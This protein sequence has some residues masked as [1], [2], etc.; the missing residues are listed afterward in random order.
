MAKQLNGINIPITLEK[1]NITELLA[2]LRAEGGKLGDFGLSE[3]MEKDLAAILKKMDDTISEMNKKSGKLNLDDI[4]AKTSKTADELSDAFAKIF[5]N[6]DNLTNMS[7]KFEEMQSSIDKLNESLKGLGASNNIFDN[8]KQKMQGMREEITT[9][10][11]ALE[12]MMNN[13]AK[14]M[15]NTDAGRGA[16]NDII[17]KARQISGL[18]NQTQQLGVMFNNLAGGDIL[19]ID[20]KELK[21]IGKGF[22]TLVDQAPLLQNALHPKTAETSTTASVDKGQQQENAKLQRA[23]ELT[24]E[25]RK[26]VK[27]QKELEAIFYLNK[28]LNE[29]FYS[30]MKAFDVDE[31]SWEELSGYINSFKADYSQLGKIDIGTDEWRTLCTRMEEARSNA[32]ALHE[33]MI[34]V[35]MAETEEGHKKDADIW[36][37]NV[38]ENIVNKTMKQRFEKSSVNLTD[39]R[40][41]TLDTEMEFL[42][43]TGEGISPYLNKDYVPKT[44]E[45]TQATKELTE[46]VKEQAQATEEKPKF[47]SGASSASDD[48]NKLAKEMEAEQDPITNTKLPKDILEF[49]EKYQQSLQDTNI[50]LEKKKELLKQLVEFAN[51]AK[52]A[53][54]KMGA[55]SGDDNNA[56]EEMQQY[57][58]ELKKFDKMQ[59]TYGGKTPETKTFEANAAFDS[60]SDPEVLRYFKQVVDMRRS[61]VDIQFIESKQEEALEVSVKE[62]NVA[63]KEKLAILQQFSQA[64]KK[65]TDADQSYEDAET[66]KQEE[67]AD[68]D[69]GVAK[70]ELDDLKKLYH[71][72]IVTA[73]NEKIVLNVD[74]DEIED[75]LNEILK[76]KKDIQDVQIISPDQGK[77]IEAYKYLEKYLTRIEK[78]TVNY[79]SAGLPGQF[80]VSGYEFKDI[81][82][83]QELSQRLQNQEQSIAEFDPEHQLG[84]PAI[85]ERVE[86]CYKNIG[87]RLQAIMQEEK[88]IGDEPIVDEDKVTKLETKLEEVSNTLTE[89]KTKLDSIGTSASIDDTIDSYDKLKQKV[90]ELA[91]AES[92]IEKNK[93]ELQDTNY[94]TFALDRDPFKYTDMDKDSINDVNKLEKAIVSY[95][96]TYKKIESAI[97]NNNGMFGGDKHDMYSLDQMNTAIGKLLTQYVEL[98]GTASNV[99]DKMTKPFKQMGVDIQTNVVAVNKNNEAYRDE[100]DRLVKVNKLAVER[101]QTIR[102]TVRELLRGQNIKE[103]GGWGISVDMDSYDRVGGDIP[104]YDGYT[105]NF[106]KSEFVKVDQLTNQ[107][108]NELGIEIPS[109]SQKMSEALKEDVAKVT[110]TIDKLEHKVVELENKMAHSPATGTAPVDTLPVETKPETAQAA[111]PDTD[112]TKTNPKTEAETQDLETLRQKVLDVEKAFGAKTQAIIAEEKQMNSS[113]SA[114]VGDLNSILE[115]VNAIKSGLESI[116]GVKLTKEAVNNP[117]TE[118]ATKASKEKAKATD[119]ETKSNQK[120]SKSQQ[121]ANANIEDAL[122]ILKEYHD[123]VEILKNGSLRT[124]DTVRGVNNLSGLEADVTKVSEYAYN[125]DT[126]LVNKMNEKMAANY[127]VAADEKVKQEK[128]AQ[129]ERVALAKKAEDE[130]IALETARAKQYEDDKE[131][132]YW[133]TREAYLTE[134]KQQEEEFYRLQKA[135]LE[136]LAQEEEERNNYIKDRTNLYT[137]LF[138]QQEKSG[139]ANDIYKEFNSDTE[140]LESVKVTES[141]NVIITTLKQIDDKI[142][143]STYKVK[144]FYELFDQDGKFTLSSATPTYKY[145]R[146][147]TSPT[148]LNEDRQAITILEKEVAQQKEKIANIAE[149]ENDQALILLNVNEK[150]LENLKAQAAVKE[151]QQYGQFGNINK[152]LDSDNMKSAQGID[153]SSFIDSSGLTKL[154]SGMDALKAKMAEAEKSGEKLSTSNING[155]LEEA[156]ALEKIRQ[157]LM[158]NDNLTKEYRN[159][160]NASAK[161]QETLLKRLKEFR[162]TQMFNTTGNTLIDSK[163]FVQ[164][165]VAVE[166]LFNKIDQ[167]TQF[168]KG[169]LKEYNEEFVQLKTNIKEATKASNKKTNSQGSSIGDI[170]NLDQV[171]EEIKAIVK[172]LN[173]GNIEWGK[174]SKNKLNFVAT[175]DKKVSEYAATLDHATKNVRLLKTSEQDYQGSTGKFVSSIGRKMGEISRYVISMGSVYEIINF[176][177][178]GV[179]L[180]KDFD[181]A[182]TE[183]AKVSDDTTETLK[184]FGKE[185]FNIAKGVSSTGKE[186]V[187]STADW[188]RLGKSMQ[189]AG[190]MAENTAIL[191]NVSEFDS[192][193]TAT[194]A[195]VAMTSAF[196][197]SADKSLDLISAL[198]EIGNN[199]AISTSQLA[200]GLQSS[201]S[202]LVASGNSL[203]EA[204]ALMTA[205]NTTVQ[206]ADKVSAGLRTIALRLRGTSVSELSE[207]GEETDGVIETVSKLES[208][209]K[210]LTAIN[211]NMGVS[212]LDVNGNYKNTYDI[213][214]SIGDIW[215]EI[216]EADIADGINRQAG[217]L[218]LMAGK[219]RSNILAAVLSNSDILESAY[220]SSKNS[221]GSAL[222]ELGTYQKSITAH[223]QE[224]INQWQELWEK[225]LDSDTLTKIVDLGT[226]I[227]GVVDNVGLLKTALV[228][229][230]ALMAGFG[231]KGVFT[232]VEDSA[233]KAG[234]KIQFLGKTMTQW[235]STFSKGSKQSVVDFD[236]SSFENF[237]KE[238][239]G[240]TAKD[241]AIANNL[242]GVSDSTKNLAQNLNQA[243]VASGGFNAR[244]AVTDAYNKKVAIS[245]K[246]A[247]AGL[248]L[249]R[250]AM[251]T[252][253]G[254]AIAIL[255]DKIITGFSNLKSESEKLAEAAENAQKVIDQETENFDKQREAVDKLT[256]SYALLAQGVDKLT[257]KNIDLKP[258]DYEDYI[259]QS[260]QIAA[261]FPELVKGYD[262]EGNAIL[263]LSGSIDEITK[264]LDELIQKQREALNQTYA[265]EMPKLF[266]NVGSNVKEYSEDISDFIKDKNSFDELYEELVSDVTNY[267]TPSSAGNGKGRM[268]FG[269]QVADD[270]NALGLSLSKYS[271]QPSKET[272]W[273]PYLLP[274][275]E[276]L[277]EA[278]QTFE[279]SYDEQIAA[280]NVKIESAYDKL[281]PNFKGWLST[282]DD[283][284]G[285]SGSMQAVVQEIVGDIDWNKVA[286]KPIEEWTEASAYIK[287]NILTMFTNIAFSPELQEAYLSLFTLKDTGAAVSTFL[288]EYNKVID[289]IKDALGLT[290]EQINQ[291]KIILGVDDSID[292]YANAMQ[293]FAPGSSDSVNSATDASAIGDKN[294]IADWISTLTQEDIT[295]LMQIDFDTNASYKTYKQRLEELKQKTKEDK[296]D[297]AGE[298]FTKTISEASDKITGLGSALAT[299]KSGDMKNSDIEELLRK[300]PELAG[301]TDNLKEAM[302]NL[303]IA[304][305]DDAISYLKGEIDS[306]PPGSEKIKALLQYVDIIDG[307]SVEA[308]N[309]TTD[310]NALEEALGKLSTNAGLLQS[311]QDDMKD[312]KGGRIALNTLQSILNTYKDMEEPVNQYLSG[313]ITAKELFAKL[314]GAYK[315]D[316]Q[317][318]ENLVRAK[319]YFDKDMY[320]QVISSN[321]NRIKELAEAYDLDWE[322]WKT[323]EDAKLT[324]EKEL[325]LDLM[326]W[327]GKYYELTKQEDGTFSKQSK[328]VEDSDMP[329]SDA[330]RGQQQAS[331]IVDRYND[332]ITELNNSISSAAPTFDTSWESIVEDTTDGAEEAKTAIDWL[333]Q[334]LENLNK[335]V[336]KTKDLFEDAIDGNSVSGY[337]SNAKEVDKLTNKY[338]KLVASR[339]KLGSNYIGNVD[340]NNRPVLL[341]DDGGYSTSRTASETLWQGDDKGQNV[342]VHYTPI[343]P[344][345]TVL[346]DKELQDY[347]NNQLNDATDILNADKISNGGL[348][349]VY[350][351][352]TNLD[353]DKANTWDK[354]LHNAQDKMYGDEAAVLRGLEKAKNKSK[355]ILKDNSEEIYAS[356]ETYKTA[357]DQQIDGYTQAQET[358]VGRYASDLSKLGSKASEIQKKIE[359][360]SKNISEYDSETAEIINSAIANYNKIK[361][362]SDDIKAATSD[363]TE[364]D[365]TAAKEI[366]SGISDY[367]TKMYDNGLMSATDYYSALINANEKYYKGVAGL[368]DE[369]LDNELDLQSKLFDAKQAEFEKTIDDTVQGFK[370]EITAIDKELKGLNKHKDEM[371]QAIQAVTD[372]WDKESER[373]GDAQ[374]AEEKYYDSKIESIQEV[375]D[376]LQEQNDTQKRQIELEKA[377]AELERLKGQKTV[378]SLELDSNGNIHKVYE[379]DTAALREAQETLEDV[380]FNNHI[381]ELE[382]SIKVQQD[383]KDI[384]VKSY[385]ESIQRLSDLKENFLDATEA[386]AKMANAESAIKFFGNDWK[387]DAIAGK[388]EGLQGFITGYTEVQKVI[389][390]NEKEKEAIQEK[391]TLVEEFKE[392]YTEEM[393]EIVESIASLGLALE[394]TLDSEQ[395]AYNQKLDALISFKQAYDKIM[396]SLDAPAVSSPA[397]PSFLKGASMGIG[398]AGKSHSGMELGYIDKSMGGAEKD[399][400]STM[401][402]R[403]LKPNEIPRILEIGEGVVTEAQ[404]LNA[405]NNMKLAYNSGLTAG[406]MQSLLTTQNNSSSFD[407]N[408]ER[409]MLPEVNNANTFVTALKNIGSVYTQELYKN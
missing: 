221:E 4:L 109:A 31:S 244:Q 160:Q 374:E 234:K 106:D 406:Q 95:Y 301:Q 263:S 284:A 97:K 370:D 59:V 148:S 153:A 204:L 53:D 294:D 169:E 316:E 192:I 249:V 264:S 137:D 118:Q 210:S 99:T 91:D 172:S 41:R 225:T 5:A 197:V 288:D 391:Q 232:T 87:L 386:F 336:S 7:D 79:K 240:G 243:T 332:F 373:L 186:I 390:D 355:L 139:Y 306:L 300:F 142:Q 299:L 407:I 364:V 216:G 30:S 15:A 55:S 84:D 276:E 310:V 266:N 127:K 26:Q 185:S 273:F 11:K 108:A 58:G 85:L 18:V 180:V 168:S 344:D 81:N 176:F 290:E 126:G 233:A 220:N 388:L 166:S 80:G 302:T 257:G 365:K 98:G 110:T 105:E 43:L 201:A 205:G 261:A 298:A 293:K 2:S 292:L 269:S 352:D 281:K 182:M 341:N 73:N 178:K 101:Y 328:Y 323:L 353:I 389:L 86:K 314:E 291:F 149:E 88:E 203:D 175:R 254:I 92:K 21:A 183:L 307:M 215:K 145:S 384:M 242:N 82:S 65:Y 343:L 74:D 51:K 171:D 327:W 268:A 181:D 348:G 260:N 138:I 77:A 366:Y 350:K 8:I 104:T 207:M 239:K 6:M 354:S 78:S 16:K 253:A 117:K 164:A 47:T 305:K 224:L 387:A 189:D 75:Q 297:F 368:S 400:F 89:V 320:K 202:A 367:Y 165:K 24:E 237:L 52:K 61:I 64:N 379:A 361:E 206:D 93:F 339:E 114:E 107:I 1:G 223:I 359:S 383:L 248:T 346:T 179:T 38:R 287:D 325:I 12:N 213:L 9:S 385:D 275:E 226:G 283:Y 27:E 71:Q 219:N 404:Q 125:P 191:M 120:F 304:S 403:P 155:F 123:K 156:R 393:K 349:I 372:V 401:T 132:K 231:N 195:M 397:I 140:K 112:A 380:K 214:K 44:K 289:Q 334:S 49:E 278:R 342:I 229:T 262:D 124:T 163:Q 228:T 40:E 96:N 394:S 311:V 395:N 347:L 152:I 279:Q 194:D 271:G 340:V 360:G 129:E 303:L 116:D 162:S 333:T 363:K 184:K 57:A 222:Q 209:I 329:G 217:L 173:L 190:K 274:T 255:L 285:L 308:L 309:A 72:F 286:D 357:I 218:E 63:L 369:Y 382:D 277:A 122:N 371:D 161:S 193:D 282:Q 227:L 235:K 33:A 150:I 256:E 113:A 319:L 37:R 409:L 76:K 147:K 10:T 170:H 121:V 177:R 56:W 154:N 17:T 35:G 251:S 230:F 62:T 46:A 326:K 208:K 381:A 312:N 211:G 135:H 134:G 322:N 317:N 338:D 14:W 69:R 313:L 100:A 39:K 405:T 68:S 32:V 167:G 50:T 94:E 199:Y 54:N 318:Y 13:K 115:K 157:S 351:V 362:V 90:Q 111:I 376:S 133:T 272:G 247:S 36:D 337:Q 42:K 335:A 128:K 241:T 280:V 196:D 267:N 83:L 60:G 188:V 392:G 159:S 158:T 408:I 102:N 399:L 45:V 396:S 29:K 119:E 258:E 295:L 331:D 198:N 25:Y 402:L 22:K 136:T 187:N 356:A 131:Y 315:L 28:D 144:D 252:F 141:G 377:Q 238:W 130:I 358:Y 296:F 34:K 330:F 250:T 246:I 321:E 67:K 259:E 324:A 212:I 66:P 245:S 48:L 265:N 3:S 236:A 174:W 23:Q 345:G 151:K 398:K 200:T 270:L 146:A 70:E 20:I 378:S 375:I 103:T 143:Q 19:P